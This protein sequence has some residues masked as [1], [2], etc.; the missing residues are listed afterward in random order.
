VLRA[1]DPRPPRATVLAPGAVVVVYAC[2]FLPGATL[3]LVRE[4]A[5]SSAQWPIGWPSLSAPPCPAALEWPMARNVALAARLSGLDGMAGAAAQLGGLFSVVGTRVARWE[6]SWCR[7]GCPELM[8][9]PPL[10]T[11]PRLVPISVVADGGLLSAP[12]AFVQMRYSLP[13]P[14]VRAGLGSRESAIVLVLVVVFAPCPELSA[15]RLR[16]VWLSVVALASS[17]LTA[18]HA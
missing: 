7:P 9:V 6:A 18:P 5:S 14:P 13:E 16:A 2:S 12:L 15:L 8:K 17:A 11:S 1:V 10:D 3:P 4:S